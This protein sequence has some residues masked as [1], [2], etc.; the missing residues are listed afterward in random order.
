[1]VIKIGWVLLAAALLFSIQ[2]GAK[3][4]YTPS[5]YLK[6]YA[7]STCI[8][9]GYQSKEVKE[10]AAAAA[11]GYLEFGDYSLAAHTAV[12]NLGKA[13]LAKEYTSQ[14]G[15]PMTLAKCIDFYHSEQLDKLVKQFKGKQD[16]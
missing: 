7:L 12:R 15:Q 3:A 9:Q 16:D 11:R 4:A 2:A 10:D 1:M 5:Q 6:N 14:S 8:S 13:F